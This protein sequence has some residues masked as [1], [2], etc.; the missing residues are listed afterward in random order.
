MP[1][2]CFHAAPAT[3][4]HHM[5]PTVPRTG[6]PFRIKRAAVSQLRCKTEFDG[7]RSRLVTGVCFRAAPTGVHGLAAPRRVAS[8]LAGNGAY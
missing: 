8:Q 6:R 3:P 4:G 2:D 7:K 1:H 5:F